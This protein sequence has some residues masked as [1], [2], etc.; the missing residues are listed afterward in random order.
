MIETK[1]GKMDLCNVIYNASGV[2]STNSSDLYRLSLDKYYNSA[3]L[4]K[5]CSKEPINYINKNEDYY[6]NNIYSI[7]SNNLN[8]LGIDFYIDYAKDFYNSNNKKKYIISTFVDDNYDVIENISN[9][10][11]YVD[12][13]ELNL[14][15]F[16][17]N[18]SVIGYDFNKMEEI[19]R[20]SSEI[21]SNSVNFGIKIPPYFDIL[22]F[23]K[24]VDIIN[25][26]SIDYITCIGNIPNGL[27][28]NYR[29]E[30]TDI[31][32]SNNNNYL[33]NIGGACIK[34]TALSNI[35]FFY[36]NTN[37]SIVGC[38]GI[39][40]GKDAFEHILCGASA[41]QI[42]TYFQQYGNIAFQ[43]ITEELKNIM[44][45]K[46]YKNINDFKGNLKYL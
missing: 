5:T 45:D 21:L 44:E 19:I 18:N 36:N 7:H 15:Y 8:N 2:Y 32:N 29:T 42:G 34:P 12:S 16:N 6:D 27:T 17:E 30:K 35:H 41:I 40:N 22:N 39:N 9:Y 46:N 10:S 26:F 24:A 43:N 1:I 38:G 28:V 3:I 13:I 11:K 33:Y 31:I 23:N 20:K 14:S 25:N 4:T 37:C